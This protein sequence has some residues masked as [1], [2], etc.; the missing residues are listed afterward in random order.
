MSDPRQ[1]VADFLS[2]KLESGI[3][4]DILFAPPKQLTMHVTTLPKTPQNSSQEVELHF[5]GVMGLKIDVEYLGGLRVLSY[6]AFTDSEFL[7]SLGIVE[8]ELVHYRLICHEGSIDIV[9]KSIAVV[10]LKP[11]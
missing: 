4:L 10:V 1:D 5:L 2:L 8:L 9:A 3:V 11:C 7:T 6:N